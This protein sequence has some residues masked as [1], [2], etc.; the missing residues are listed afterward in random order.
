[1]SRRQSD[2]AILLTVVLLMFFVGTVVTMQPP[3]RIVIYAVLV[4]AGIVW[5]YG[6][7]GDSI[8]VRTT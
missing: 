7:R 3:F 4:L 1:M 8:A 2:P 5:L 6:W